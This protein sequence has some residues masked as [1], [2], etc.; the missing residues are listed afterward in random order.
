MAVSVSDPDGLTGQLCNWAVRLQ[1][2]K[3]PNDVQHRAKLILLDGIS[4]GLVGAHLQWSET[5][6][7]TVLELE[8]QGPCSVIGWD[9]SVGGSAATLLNSTLIQG[10]EL[11]DWH[12]YAPL[13]SAALLIPALLSAIE[14][15]KMVE[16]RSISGESMLL[17]MIV[18]LEVGPRI[19]LGLGGGEML[20]RGW[21]SGA[22]FGGPAVAIAVSKVL[23][24]SPRQ[25][26]WALGTACTQAGGLMSAQF[27]SM[28]KRMQHGFA[29]RNGFV[30]AFLARGGYT[31]IEAVLEREYGGF[32]STFNPT[33]EQKSASKNSLL[34][35]LGTVWEICNIQIKAY[36]LMGTL[37]AAVDCI[38]QLQDQHRMAN[39]TLENI[40]TIKIGMGEAPYKHGG[41]KVETD[42]L[43]P[44]GAQMSAAYAVA[45]QLIDGEVTTSSF[46]PEKLNRKVLHQL[47]GKIECTHHSEFDR[48]LK[49]RIT[50]QLSDDQIMEASVESPRG[51]KPKLTD[52]EIMDKTI[53]SLAGCI[54]EHRRQSI[55]D[56]VMSI[57]GSNDLDVLIAK[58]KESAGAIMK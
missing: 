15:I 12:P 25:M 53:T 17:A 46:V 8:P 51:V 54:D 5:A 36:P 29:A 20:S 35:N 56:S 11:D 34:E 37:H 47:I 38:R 18:G 16:N 57:E 26:E 22:V 10:F 43:E 28:T 49:T 21:H 4:C 14:Q 30:A 55:V 58:L 44:T 1:L 50:I 39:I 9:K 6:V 27:G 31:G 33:S 3:V 2:S 40:K 7:K 13:H 48:S 19:G 23:E 45:V 24:L 42:S 52:D 41:W 32:L